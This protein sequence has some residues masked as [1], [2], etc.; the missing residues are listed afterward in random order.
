[1]RH[2][3]RAFKCINDL[4]SALKWCEIYS[5]TPLS[6]LGQGESDNPD[7]AY[8]VVEWPPINMLTVDQAMGRVKFLNTLLD[9]M[10]GGGFIGG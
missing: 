3:T 10:P 7:S 8:V 5:F 2:K 4:Q 9:T 6:F 1:M